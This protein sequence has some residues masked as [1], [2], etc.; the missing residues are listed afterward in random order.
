[1]ND[2]NLTTNLSLIL[3]LSITLVGSAEVIEEELEELEQSI[4]VGSRQLSSWIDQA[5]S[6]SHVSL[7][8][9]EERFAR[10]LVDSLKQTEGVLVQKT[11]TGQGSPFIRGFTGYRTLALIDGVRY[12][13]SVYRDGPNEYFSLIDKG[14]I[15][16]LE[17]IHGPSSVAYGNDAIGGT[18][19]LFTK[20]SDYEAEE[21]LYSRGSIDYQFSSA[22]SSHETR[23]EYEFGNGGDWGVRL[24]IGAKL[25]GNVRS[26]NIGT[27]PNTGYDEYSFDLRFDKRLSS[28]W[29]LTV[30]HQQLEQDDVWRTHSTIFARSFVFSVER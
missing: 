21:G 6:V 27:Q 30:V 8:N 5:Y 1:M 19:S 28:A 10:N 24:G 25:Y 22:S 12:N 3:L 11:S 20:K 23:A 16:K 7:G 29:E 18:I 17:L 4:V 14:S 2:Q 15:E 13:N 9:A 26:A